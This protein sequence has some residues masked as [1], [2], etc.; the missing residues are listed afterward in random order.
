MTRQFAS[1]GQISGSCAS[2]LQKVHA[3]RSTL[4]S[5]FCVGQEG[6]VATLAGRSA[7]IVSVERGVLDSPGAADSWPPLVK[8]EL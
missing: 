1:I 7:T 3:Y 4:A 5:A 8:A 6:S 2:A